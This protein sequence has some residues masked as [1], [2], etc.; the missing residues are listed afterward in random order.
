MAPLTG[1]QLISTLCLYV[2]RK[3]ERAKMPNCDFG[4][5]CT[6]KECRTNIRNEICP[7][8]GFDNVIEIEGAGEIKT[9]RKGIRYADITYPTGNPQNLDCFKCGHSIINVEFYTRISI[10]ECKANMKRDA[11]KESSKPCDDCNVNIQNSLGTYKEI[12]LFEHKGNF[13][14]KECLAKRIKTEN[15]DPSDQNKKF[16]FNNNDL[17]WVLSKVRVKC[18]SCGKPR[19]LMP[20]NS[21]KNQCLPCFKKA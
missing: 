11:I 8:C 3:K 7:S 21:W 12:K 18:K 4:T 9:D 6:C 2:A 1:G 14:C 17:K 13:L 19:W 5:P 15:P 16:T 20:E 10:P